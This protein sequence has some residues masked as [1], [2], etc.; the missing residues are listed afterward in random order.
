[1]TLRQEKVSE[2]LRNITA[3]FL[4]KESN[5]ESLITVTNA[6]VSPDLK[7]AVVYITV[8]PEDKE[9]AALLFAKRKRKELRNYV[10]SKTK[11][12]ALPFLDIEIDKG[13]KLE[14]KISELQ[15]Q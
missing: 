1:M 2:L 3:E 5:R 9:P 4:E 14:Q 11:F 12:R 15:I 6:I 8:L 7:K 13:Q 10:K